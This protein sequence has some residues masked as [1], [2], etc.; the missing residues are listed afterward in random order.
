MTPV[1]AA[2]DYAD[3]AADWTLA[4]AREHLWTSKFGKRAPGDD[5]LGRKETETRPDACLRIL[6][7]EVRRLQ[8]LRN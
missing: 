1:E 2:L 8:S 5:L 3:Y 7:A 6:A 4:T